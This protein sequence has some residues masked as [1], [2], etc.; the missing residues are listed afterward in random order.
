MIQCRGRL[1]RG[2]LTALRP[3]AGPPKQMQLMLVGP[4]R[5]SPV[6]ANPLPAAVKVAGTIYGVG[7]LNSPFIGPG[8][9]PAD[10]LAGVNLAHAHV[11]MAR[12]LLSLTEGLKPQEYKRQV[13]ETRMEPNGS[14]GWQSIPNEMAN[15]AHEITCQNGAEVITALL[16]QLTVAN[17]TGDPIQVGR[18]GEQ[19][20]HAAGYA[21]AHQLANEVLQGEPLTITAADLNRLDEL[22]EQEAYTVASARPGAPS[23]AGSVAGPRV[24]LRGRAEG[25]IVLQEIKRKLTTPQYNV[26]KALLDAGDAGLTKDELVSRSGHE[27]ARGILKRLADS[28]PDWNE[29]I[30]FAGLTGGGYRVK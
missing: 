15:L 17:T 9:L 11:S 8:R 4:A 7:S 26:V 21:A 3:P 13:H 27:D 19:T 2:A 16:G 5:F 12:R 22:I 29:V 30:H 18:V 23:A 28:D 20:A 25:P 24:I 1:P 10:L 6:S 14:G